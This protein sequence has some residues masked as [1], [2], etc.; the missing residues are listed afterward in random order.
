M[1]LR[2]REGGPPSAAALVFTYV[3]YNNPPRRRCGCAAWWDRCR[4]S[5]LFPRSSTYFVFPSAVLACMRKVRRDFAT[6]C[7]VPLGIGWRVEGCST[8]HRTTKERNAT[9]PMDVLRFASEHLRQSST[10][11]SLRVD[12]HCRNSSSRQERGGR[13]ESCS[14]TP[15]LPTPQPKT[16]SPADKNYLARFFVHRSLTKASVYHLLYLASSRLGRASR[17]ALGSFARL[18]LA[19][20]LPGPVHPRHPYHP[21]LRRPRTPPRYRHA[22]SR[23]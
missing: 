22:P 20:P 11:A 1:K 16:H 4:R 6:H 17:I 12:S 18:R 13:K 9:Q 21:F 2:R 14:V 5:L 8:Q 23:F 3:R 19:P 15:G 10:R 7:C